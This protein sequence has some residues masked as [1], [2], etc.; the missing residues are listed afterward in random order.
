MSEEYPLFRPQSELLRE[1]SL[2]AVMEPGRQSL[3]RS[4]QINVAGD[5]TRINKIVGFLYFRVL[6]PGLLKTSRVREPVNINDVDE[7]NRGFRINS[8]L[9]GGQG[10]N[11]EIARHGRHQQVIDCVVYINALAQGD[12]EVDLL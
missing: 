6:Q 4:E 10:L 8:P 11:P 7:L 5:E 1:A 3:C 9:T 2:V 12:I